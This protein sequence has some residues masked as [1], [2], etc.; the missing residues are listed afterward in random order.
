MNELKY[1]GQLGETGESGHRRLGIGEAWGLGAGGWGL[2]A[3]EGLVFSGR[4]S[5]AEKREE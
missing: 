5:R 3:G 1:V 4:R 2:G